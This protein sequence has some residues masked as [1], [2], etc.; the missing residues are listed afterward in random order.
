[1]LVVLL[2]L[3]WQF[4]TSEV[5]VLWLSKFVKST[6]ENHLQDFRKKPFLFSLTQNKGQNPNYFVECHLSFSLSEQL[7]ATQVELERSDC[8]SVNEA[9]NLVQ[10]C[11]LPVQILPRKQIA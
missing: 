3:G 2:L 5:T 11:R 8:S 1:M 4:L 9:I 10:C 7:L 6:K